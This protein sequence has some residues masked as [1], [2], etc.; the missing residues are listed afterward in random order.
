MNW[1]QHQD[2]V[3]QEND[4]GA[5]LLHMQS[6][7]YFGLDE[8]GKNIWHQFKT[9]TTEALISKYLIESYNLSEED[10]KQDS[11]EFI[12]S[13]KENNLIVER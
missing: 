7:I 12:Q 4:E 9:P 1:I 8:V 10:A 2:V 13:L 11:F 3:T 6:G 5:F